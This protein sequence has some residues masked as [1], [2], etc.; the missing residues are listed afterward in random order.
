[1]FGGGGGGGGGGLGGAQSDR[2]NFKYSYFATNT[3][4]AT[5][6]GDFS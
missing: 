4:T 5:K 6:F 1:M 3:A 2:A